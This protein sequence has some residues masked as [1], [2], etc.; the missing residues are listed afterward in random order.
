MQGRDIVI[1]ASAP[2]EAD[3]RI[4]CHHVAR[5]LARRNRVLYVESPGLR[6]PNPFHRADLLKVLRRLHRW[7]SGQLSGPPEVLPNCYLLS[8]LV[9][10]FHGEPLAA[11]CNAAWLGSSCARCAKALGFSRPVLWSF[12]PTAAGLVGRLEESAVIYHCVDDYAGNP[13]VNAGMVAQAERRLVAAADLCFATSRPLAERLSAM[14]ARV[15]CVPNVAEVER[16]GPPL[17]QSPRELA[18]LPRPVVGYVGNVASY[19]VD[20]ELLGEVAARR[21][22]WSLVLVGPYG[23]GDPSTNLGALRS[24]RNVHLLGPRPYDRIPAYVHGF[25]VC[26][27]PF[28]RNRVT[29]SALPLKTFEYLAA[30]KPV[31]SRALPAL[32]AE[33]LA[34][35]LHYAETAEEFVE[36]IEACFAHDSAARR[37][38]RREVAARYSWKRRFPEIEACVARVLTQKEVKGRP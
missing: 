24:Q 25:D 4:N 34:R 27:V 10:P 31:V 26:L 11:R 23:G 7:L 12:L 17:P 8:P 1:L 37:R 5:R 35:V 32:T 18:R 2:W 15:V 19:M 28:R 9:L 22:D 6:A 13:G 38:A 29:E 36:A 3:G 16:F 21:P 33:P 30:G 14:G 20:F